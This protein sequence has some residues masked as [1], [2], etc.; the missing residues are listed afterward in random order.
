MIRFLAPYAIPLALGALTLIAALSAALWLSVT[1]HAET[2]QE[3]DAALD[4]I[5]NIKTGQ[6]ISND[7]QSMD[8][9]A[10]G[11]DLDERLSDGGQ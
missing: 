1:S 2:R 4:R 11:S 9:A 7:V 5:D 8:D 3:R 6:E 10:I